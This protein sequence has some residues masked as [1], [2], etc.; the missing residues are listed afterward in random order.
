[1]KELLNLLISG[2]DLTRD[3]AAAAMNTIMSGEA[4]PAQVA[5]F[6]IALR[7]KGETVDEIT[8]CAR[9]MREK[10]TRVQTPA[11]AMVIDTCGTG[12]DHA[13]TFNIS[14]AAA[15]VAAACGLTVAKHGNRSVTSSSGSADVLKTLGVNIEADVPT[16]ERCLA[17][18]GIGFLFAPLLHGAMKHAV[19]PRREL[20]V[21]TIFNVLGP[22]TNPAGARRQVMGVFDVELVEP[23]AHV[24][25]NL[26]AERA[27]VVAGGDGL[28]EISLAGASRIAEATPGGVKVYDIT[29]DD[30]GLDPC[31]VDE[32]KVDSPEASADVIRKILNGEPGAPR[33]VVLAN[34]AAALMAG[35]AAS[36][37]KD[38]V[39]RAA[40]AIDSGRARETLAKLVAV[41]GG[42]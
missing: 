10:A 20:G 28:D 5:G 34:A 8:G 7:I 16:V 37:L 30:L 2:K 31:T 17:E 27:L 33:R 25:L 15:I 26:G 32:L 40:K 23:L 4:T 14:T 21:R 18:A 1:M 3:Q 35:E 13:G 39:S 12:G 11:G 41:S 24:L 36:D 38:A 9:V 29:P 19:G 42:Q 22:L 6:L